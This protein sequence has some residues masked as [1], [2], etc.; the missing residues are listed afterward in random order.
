MNV[1][2]LAKV[3]KTEGI[4]RTSSALA[5]LGYGLYK[6]AT[7]PSLPAAALVTGTIR[8]STPTGYPLQGFPVIITAV[9]SGARY[10]DG[11]A[12]TALDLVETKSTF[13]TDERGVAEI[14]LAKGARVRVDVAGTSLSRELTVPQVDFDML[15]SSLPGEFADGLSTPTIAPKLLVRSDR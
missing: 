8:I 7:A 10:V 2:E 1:E 5:Q 13:Y 3:I 15:D 4:Q 14:K 9:R 12:T 11:G 6:I